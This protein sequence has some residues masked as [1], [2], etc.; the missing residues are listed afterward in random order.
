[1][2][3]NAQQIENLRILPFNQLEQLYKKRIGQWSI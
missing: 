1:M 3:N 2:I